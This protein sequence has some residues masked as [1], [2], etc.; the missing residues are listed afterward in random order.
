M[1]R[2]SRIYKLPQ[3][4][5]SAGCPVLIKAGALLKDN[6]MNKILAQ[7]KFKNVSEKAIKELVV[8]LE[9]YDENKGAVQGVAEFVYKNLNAAGGGEFGQQTPIELPD[10]SARSYDVI[11]K[12]AVFADGTTWTAETVSAAAAV[13]E[14]QSRE[15]QE[16][17]EALKY[18]KKRSGAKKLA[19]LPLIL[20]GAGIVFSLIGLLIFVFV[21]NK[22][23]DK[24]YISM[25][26]VNNLKVGNYLMALVIPAAA[27]LLVLKGKNKGDFKAGGIVSFV[28]VGVQVLCAIVTFVTVFRGSSLLLNKLLSGVNGNQLITDLYGLVI[29]GAVMNKIYRFVRLLSG[30]CYLAKNVV[31]GIVFMKMSK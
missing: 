18:E 3:E 24:E 27:L 23:M 22:G 20:A 1:E 30:G 14:E 7:L 26:F 31:S 21:I 16:K 29:K 6:S 4:L 25:L 28:I 13:T 19:I 2:Y 15:L 12:K 10:A 9:A 8:G 5:Y 17:Q 11:V